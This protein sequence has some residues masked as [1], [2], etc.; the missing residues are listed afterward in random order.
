MASNLI[1]RPSQST[2]LLID[3]SYYVFY[4]YYATYNWC[5]R[6]ADTQ[7][8]EVDTIMQNELFMMKYK[9]MFE[10]SIL[11]LC[12]VNKIKKEH[13]KNVVFVKDCARDHIWRHQ[14]MVGY[15]ACREDKTR[16]FN[17][18]V[19]T[20]TYHT[21]LP[22]LITK[23][24]FQCIGFHTLEADDVIAI[25]S[26]HLM[27]TYVNEY[28]LTISI[29]TNDND[30]IQLLNH[31][32]LSNE[33]TNCSLSIKNLQDKHIYERTGYSSKEYM[34]IKKIIGDKSD[35]IPSIIKKCGDKTAYKLAMQPEQLTKLLSTNHNA[36]TQYEL[37]CLLIDF[38]MIPIELKESVLEKLEIH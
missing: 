17:K 8:I 28:N 14:Y 36:K 21:L 31:P 18:E 22:E 7:D 4:R 15:K 11:D 3:T 34:A 32:R 26:Q 19:F 29:I 35:N 33:S 10:K 16:T 2:I 23:Y 6:Q 24:N 13:Y 20:Y 9:K 38:E 1:L 25:I 27:N 12:K 37:N 5:K 30:Y